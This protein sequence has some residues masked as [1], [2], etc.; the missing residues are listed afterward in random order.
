MTTQGNL[1]QEDL[2]NLVGTLKTTIIQTVM[3][4]DSADID[5]FYLYL[6]G[7]TQLLF[8]I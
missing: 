8:V 5:P 7:K 2:V 1:T 3:Q 4:L 6:V